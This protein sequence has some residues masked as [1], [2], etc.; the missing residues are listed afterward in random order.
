MR[1]AVALAIGRIAEAVARVAQARAR[2]PLVGVRARRPRS[3]GS[4]RGAVSCD[5]D[6]EPA[7]RASAGRRCD[8]PAPRRR[9]RRRASAAA[10]GRSEQMDDR[11]HGVVAVDAVGV[12]GGAGIEGGAADRAPRRSAT[13]GRGRR[14]RRVAAT[15]AGKPADRA[16]SP[17]RAARCVR[18]SRSGSVTRT[19]LPTRR[20]SGRRR[21]CSRGGRSA[22]GVAASRAWPR[23]GWPARARR[24]ARYDGFVARL[25]GGGEDHRVER[26]GQAVSAFAGRRGRLRSG[27]APAGGPRSRRRSPQHGVAARA[28]S[29]RRALAEPAAA[30]DQDARHCAR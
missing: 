10:A 27:A 29:D 20:R 26:R 7:A 4:G 19:R 8:R 2:A 6:A 5:V 22:A 30:G 16:T 28:S 12:A 24:C 25:G 21:W 14:A 11:A 15:I 9:R 3:S 18:G 1:I 13:R 23:A 17:R